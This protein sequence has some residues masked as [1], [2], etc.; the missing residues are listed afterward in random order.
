MVFLVAGTGLLIADFVHANTEITKGL[1]RNS[2]GE[3]DRE[4]ELQVETSGKTGRSNLKIHV[5]EQAYTKKQLKSMFQRCIVRME[6]EMLGE[7]R[8]LDRVEKDLN[9]M[10]SIDGFPVEISWELDRY[11]VMNVYGEL[12]EEN[13]KSDGTLVKLQAV[14]T[15]KQDPVEQSIFSCQAMVFPATLSRD[16]QR[17][18]AIQNEIETE[19]QNTQTKK[20]L[21]LPKKAGGEDVAFYP[22][23]DNR[24]VIF[25]GMAVLVGILSFF[26]EKQNNK[27]S[28][29]ERKYQM[30]LD[31]PE[32]VSKLTLFLGAGMTVKRAW[33][34]IVSDYESQKEEW[35]I[36]YAYEEMKQACNEM[37]S[38]IT[39][40]ESYERFG[41]RCGL[42]E[43]IKLGALLSQN[44]RKG[45]KGLSQIL[46][47]EAA[48]S[49]EERK[50]RA[51]RKG[52]ETGTK[53]LIPMSLMLVVVLVIVIVPAFM[54][55]QL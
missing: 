51:K 2:Y 5:S 42:Q 34:K 8:S 16:E 47:A 27:K 41:K 25:L 23:M 24:G 39:E 40:V 38:G 35:G 14:L 1:E 45:S 15:Y 6:T 46:K 13:L 55:V 54:S 48:Q 17:I 29:E 50:A 32:I 20:N 49:F 9:L 7:N 11:D 21:I 4:E 19:D 43:Y 36:R 26:L 28:E 18:A 44:I 3:G 22:I 37:N 10:T 12:Q 30:E 53:L 31:Y 33:K 52:E